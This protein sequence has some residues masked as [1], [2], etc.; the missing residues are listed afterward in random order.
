MGKFYKFDYLNDTDVPQ[1][2]SILKARIYDLISKGSRQYKHPY[3]VFDGFVERQKNSQNFA[4]YIKDKI[5]CII[6][7][8][9]NYKPEAWNDEFNCDN[10]IWFTS[11]FTNP[12][13]KGE[14]YG[15][16]LLRESENYAC[17]KNFDF[18]YLDCYTGT[19]FLA[20]YYKKEGYKVVKDKIVKYPVNEFKASLMVKNLKY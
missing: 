14:N 17:R 3:P 16:S 20:N 2:Y 12:T 18:A 15:L 7:I 13:F 6:S 19:E 11:L 9:P 10:F 4:L 5:A 8:M 1:A